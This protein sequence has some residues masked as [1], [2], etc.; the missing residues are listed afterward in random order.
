MCQS[1]RQSACTR[2]EPTPM[3]VSSATS[4]RQVSSS[5]SS[6]ASFEPVTLCQKP[7]ASARSSSSTS[8]AALWMTTR[9][10]SG[11]LNRRSS[12]MSTGGRLRAA[13]ADVQLAQLL[14]VDRT[15]RVGEEVLRALRL[16]EGDHVAQ[17]LCVDEQHDEAVEADGD[18]AV[19]RR[20]V[21]Q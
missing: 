15:G 21:L 8:S 6:S 3:P 12:I 17:R 19:R 5:G 9:T 18:A 1:L 16:R 10:D 13:Q 2:A 4:R 20:A 7:G 14:L 11:I